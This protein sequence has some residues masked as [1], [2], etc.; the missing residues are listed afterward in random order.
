MNESTTM[1]RFEPKI[2]ESEWRLEW[3]KSGYSALDFTKECSNFSIQLPPPN[4]TGT[5]H[6][7]HAFN[8]TIIDSLTRYHRMLGKNVLSVPGTDHAGIA[9]QIIIERQLDAQNISRYNIGREKFIE[10][11]WKW[12]EKSGSI[13][14]A[15]IRRLG[16]SLNWSHEYFTMN[17][18]MSIIVRDVFI[19]LYEQGLI[20]R[21]KRLVNWDPVLMT[22]VSDLEVSSE[23]E[24]GYLWYIR[25]PLINHEGE[26]VI[27]TTRPETMFGDA[28]VMINPSDDR[29]RHLIGKHVTLPLCDR[30]IPVIADNYVDHKFGTGVVKVT[31]A[32][33]FNDYQIGLRHRLTPIEILT[34][35]AKI[36]DNAPIRYQGLDR[37]DARKELV[38]DL[39][40]YGFLYSVEPHKIMVPRGD[41]TG[42]II[43]PMLTNQWFIAM[44][45]PAP[46]GTL[47]PG[48]SISEISI[49]VV[50]SGKIQFIPKNWTNTYYQWL[51]NI[52]DWCISRQLWWG[53]RI[54]A[55]YGENGEIFVTRDED[56]ARAQA[57]EMGY[58]GS[59]KQDDDV[60]DTWF[61]SAL[62]PFSSLGWPDDTQELKQFL[63][64]SVL[65]TG[66]DIIFFWV[67]RMIM[68][69]THFTGKIPFHTVYIHGLIRDGQGQK[70]SK[71][72]GNILDPIDIIDG[73]DLN[74][75]IK[76]RTTGLTNRNQAA[77]I[78]KNTREEF[79]NGI[80]AS[81]TDALRFTMA[82]IATFGRDLNF[83]LSR[84]E[85]YRNFC[86]KLWNATRFVLMNCEGYDYELDYPKI[87]SVEANSLYDYINFSQADRWIISLLQRTVANITKGFEDY[88]FDNIAINIYRFIWDEY[89]DWYIE[90]AKVQIQNGTAEQRQATRLTLIFIL[91][92]VLRLAHPIIPFITE[93]LWQRVAPLSGCYMKD[94]KVKN[95][96][97][98]LITQAYPVFSAEKIDDVA[99]R[100]ITDLKKIVEACRNM[101]SK[102]NLSPAKK[103]PLLASGEA[104][105]LQEFAPYIKALAQL[106]E[107]QIFMEEATLDSNAHGSPIMIVGKNKLALKIEIDIEV[108]RNR[109]TKE[110]TH[111][112]Y[113][114]KRCNSKLNNIEFIKNAPPTIVEKERKRINEFHNTLD[115][116]YEQLHH[117]A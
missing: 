39:E 28:A 26:L 96:T 48:K 106:S 100:W 98:L 99:E 38:A 59:L 87:F 29:Y 64:S 52:Q 78:E 82:S 62:V 97:K 32:H 18:K 9:T 58:T 44:K 91:E 31:P 60:L 75:L 11:A 85:G 30:T 22:A 21:G 68:M 46:Y 37:L 2:I 111:L 110:I 36:N 77:I 4:V 93:E 89:C 109:L 53:H 105:L 19:T 102:M 80:Q 114:I 70:M 47:N 94:N 116:L 16:V 61:S 25:Y 76:K 104:K 15:Q 12:K 66:F 73:I 108:E 17:D 115:K 74:T 113:E 65:V 3:E 90:L 27:A 63:P 83:D 107:I 20:Y 14:T 69:T 41:R 56:C 79:P 43:E 5:L 71:S 55:W 112:T 40:T 84:C 101:R 13:I 7:G 45:K 34:F 35:D 54:P 10:Y 67:A 50:R 51:E 1:K 23:E 57:K 88:R 117:I 95:T 81:G 8:Q 92:T 24:N 72:K 49:D 103:I 33:D 42:A 6:M 86:N